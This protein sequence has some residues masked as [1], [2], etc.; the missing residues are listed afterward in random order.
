MGWQQHNRKTFSEEIEKNQAI[1]HKI[2]LVYA[3]NPN[4][5]EDLFQEVCLQL[6]TSYASF[7][8]DSKFTTWLYRVALNT[9][10]SYVRSKKNSFSFEPLE[11]NVHLIGDCSD[12]KEQV[13]ALHVAISRLNR[14]DKAIILLWLEERSYEE[15][16]AIL[17]IS[18]SNVSVKLV[19]IKKKLEELMNAT[20]NQ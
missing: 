15:I 12:K 13:S 5:R 7:R 3:N 10:I 14:I 6:W 4:D 17:G 9:A 19:R 18:K 16:S 20:T 2:T 8:E 1:I 11:E